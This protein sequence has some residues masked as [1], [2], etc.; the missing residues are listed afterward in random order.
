MSETH[1]FVQFYHE[2][3][4]INLMV[5]PY[6]VTCCYNKHKYMYGMCAQYR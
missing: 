5:I 2:I 1:L 4:S 6:V 3:E